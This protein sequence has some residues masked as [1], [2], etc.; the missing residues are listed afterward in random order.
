ML[1]ASEVQAISAARL[2]G[3]SKTITQPSHHSD[4]NCTREIINME[5][6][7]KAMENSN[8]KKKGS[9]AAEGFMILLSVFDE[10][11]KYERQ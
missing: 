3:A 4:R 1:G 10:R 6:C 2:V 5:L 11:D 8:E 7:V 9:L